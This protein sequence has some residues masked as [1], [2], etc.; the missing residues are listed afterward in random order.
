MDF[1]T[2]EVGEKRIK[3]GKFMAGKR[4]FI[5]PCLG[6][7]G[8]AIGA[9]A[10]FLVW[11]LW[12]ISPVTTVFLVRHAEKNTR[13]MGDPPLT[14]AGQERSRTLSL[15][16]QEAKIS[17]IYSTSFVRTRQTA[18]PLAEAFDLP[19]IQYEARDFK[20]L[21]DQIVSE[22]TGEVILVV[23]HSNTVPKIIEAFG[24]DP[25]MPIADNEYDNLFALS[26]FKDR[27]ARVFIL[28]Y[29]Q[30]NLRMDRTHKMQLDTE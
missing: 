30:P 2:I 26:L 19:I 3:R 20:G 9:A 29:G 5:K 18:R 1:I 8:I 24:A 6:Y 12:V 22:H 23:G 13:P 15:I 27:K 11:F 16:L 14:A 17:A 7:L 4:N 28:K 21:V 25:V 10:L